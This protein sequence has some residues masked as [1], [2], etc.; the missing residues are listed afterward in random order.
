MDVV[1]ATGGTAGHIFPAIALARRLRERDVGVTF[2]GT[3]NGQEKQLVPEAGFQLETVEVEPIQDRLSLTALRA[4]LVVARAVRASRPTVRGAGAVVGMGGYASVAAVLAAY[5]TRNPVIIHEQNAVPGLANR[6]GAR[7]ARVVALSFE[8]A[9]SKLPKRTR[10]VVTGNP[11]RP[12]ILAVPDAREAL[13]EEAK[14]T[15][16]LEEGRKTV[17]VFGGSQGALHI[18]RAI[19]E[20]SRWLRERADIQLLVVTGPAHRALVEGA[21][22]RSGPLRSVVLPFLDRMDLAYSLADLV[23]SRAGATTIAELTVCGLASVLVPYPHATENHQ[24]ANAR[25]LERRD[26]ASVMLD[27]QLSG[28]SLADAIGS[29]IADEPALRR[30][31]AAAAGCSFPDADE[32]L[33]NLVMGL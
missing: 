29:M 21:I 31:G 24:E 3:A 26:A 4:P 30:M 33:A 11:V 19:C 18:D 7:V 5:S 25:A 6:L 15:F 23:V 9:R 22:D 8:E 13:A 32:R 27:R 28:G 16:G 14:R 17:L 20:A 12:E 10:T 1:I 2:I